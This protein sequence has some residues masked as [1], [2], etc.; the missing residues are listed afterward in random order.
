MTLLSLAHVCTT[1]ANT[2]AQ[3]ILKK[4]EELTRDQ[5]P[6]VRTRNLSS[7]NAKK[8]RRSH[9]T[10]LRPGPATHFAAAGCWLPLCLSA[11]APACACGRPSVCGRFQL[12]VQERGLLRNLCCSLLRST[13]VEHLS[14]WMFAMVTFQTS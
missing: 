11:Y 5:K 14:R 1:A 8:L 6:S 10:T 4:A 13:L 2:I 3:A 12:T 7:T 9:P